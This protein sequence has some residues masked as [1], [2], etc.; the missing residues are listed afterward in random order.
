MGGTVTVGVTPE[1]RAY[2]YCEHCGELET[3]DTSPKAQ[4]W[5]DLHFNFMHAG[6]GCV[7][8]D[9]ERPLQTPGG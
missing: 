6:F 7:S 8:C 1:G 2:A 9:A 4:R 5:L 3:R